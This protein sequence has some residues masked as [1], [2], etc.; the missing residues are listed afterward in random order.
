MTTFEDRIGRYFEQYPSAPRSALVA[1]RLIFFVAQRLDQYI[2]TALAPYGLQR[3]QYLLMTVLASKERANRVIT[4]S[5]LG[6]ILDATR[7]QITRLLDGL[8]ARGLVQRNPVLKD[9]RSFA[10]DLTHTGEAL[11]RQATPAVHGAHERLW[12]ELGTKATTQTIEHLRQL[13]R[14]LGGEQ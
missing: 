1:S 11:F 13:Y 5:E 14:H 8:E 7:T 9:R 10:V 3:R 4:P 12:E 6:E 2:D